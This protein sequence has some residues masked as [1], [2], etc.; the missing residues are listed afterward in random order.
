[1]YLNDFDHPVSCIR[2]FP[3]LFSALIASIIW[4]SDT[5]DHP[6]YLKTKTLD[7]SVSCTPFPGLFSA[8]IVSIICL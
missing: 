3:R 6:M 8:I 1:M 2:P 4:H 5:L 7:H